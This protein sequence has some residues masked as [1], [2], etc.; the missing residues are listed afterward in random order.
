M[1]TPMRYGPQ[2]GAHRPQAQPR[3]GPRKFFQIL[4]SFLLFEERV[5]LLLLM[6]WTA[7]P[8]SQ[9]PIPDANYWAQHHA[10]TIQ[11]DQARRRALKPTDLDLPEGSLEF[12]GEIAANYNALRAHEKRLDALMT[13]KMMEY[14]DRVMT[15]H[16]QRRRC[17]LHIWTE[18][19]N[20][21]WQLD[22][23]NGGFDFNNGPA[24]YKVIIAG[25]LIKYPW[26]KE[27][28]AADEEESE[29]TT[30]DGAHATDIQPGTATQNLQLN[31]Y[32]K[33]KPQ[34]KLASTFF[35]SITVEYERG[36]D[37][38]DQYPTFSW[39]K[40]AVPPNTAILPKEVNFSHWCFKR[41]SDQNLNITLH[42]QRDENPERWALSEA[43]QWVVDETDAARSEIITC[44]TEYIK[45]H[46]LQED[47]D[48][49]T[50]RCDKH[51][52][53][54]SYSVL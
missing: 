54:V 36:K 24:T 5:L 1:A 37:F 40:P 18:V 51:L 42:F 27:K 41:N 8:Q 34:E 29:E 7:A 43:L 17:R 21:P 33:I 23:D 9:P 28:E 12:A 48:K 45:F 53:A 14:Q 35:K 47:D 49:R 10:A 3:R 13:R 31:P 52:K 11:Q 6:F 46:K 22:A 19:E 4:L 25:Y 50:I 30:A 44:I 39:N 26:E 2:Q 20:Q 15:N 16:K 38:P 32:K